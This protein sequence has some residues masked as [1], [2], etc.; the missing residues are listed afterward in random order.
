MR[1]W[2]RRLIDWRE[3]SYLTALPAASLIE[4]GGCYLNWMKPEAQKLFG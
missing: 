2:C 3:V 1:R 4:A